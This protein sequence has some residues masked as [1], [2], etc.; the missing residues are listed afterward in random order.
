[1]D[2]LNIVPSIVHFLLKNE[3]QLKEFDV[4]SVKT[5]L[6]GSAPI[7][8]DLIQKFTNKFTHIE[9]FLQGTQL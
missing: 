5:V 7:G 2:T 1:M 3:A 4:S 6:C 9:K 8:K